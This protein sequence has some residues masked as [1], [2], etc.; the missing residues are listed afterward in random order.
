MLIDLMRG[1]SNL[2]KMCVQVQYE[3]PLSCFDKKTTLLPIIGITFHIF[4]LLFGLFCQ[5]ANSWAF[6][7]GT[8]RYT[9]YANDISNE[10]HGKHEIIFYDSTKLAIWCDD[11]SCRN[12]SCRW[13]LAFSMN[14]LDIAAVN[15]SEASPVRH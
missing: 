2:Y 14:C 4:V 11:N 13:P 12:T 6:W 7:S 8:S 1:C 5:N 10:D 3:M 9:V 15:A